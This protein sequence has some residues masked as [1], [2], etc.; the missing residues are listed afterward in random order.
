MKQQRWY[1]PLVMA[2]LRSPFRRVLGKTLLITVTGRKSHTRYTV[3][4]CYLRAGESLLIL[5]SA[6]KTWW[7]NLSG[8]APVTVEME[9]NHLAGVG[10]SFTETSVVAKGLLRFLHASPRYQK[11]F[12]VSF[13][14]EKQPEDPAALKQATA[15]LVLVCVRNLRVHDGAQEMR[16]V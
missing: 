1:N 11:A 5:T 12:H 10:E 2:L 9:G 8:G 3:P 13:N 14:H 16:A 15:N 6:E 7:K 4:V